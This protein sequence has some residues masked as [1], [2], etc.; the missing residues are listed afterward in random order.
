MGLRIGRVFSL[1]KNLSSSPQYRVR[2]RA[3]QELCQRDKICPTKQD[4]FS[5][6]VVAPPSA[7][8]ASDDNGA[9][10]TYLAWCVAA[11]A[12][13]ASM[14][15]SDHHS[16]TTGCFDNCSPRGNRALGARGYHSTVAVCESGSSS[17]PP[18]RND[19]DDCSKSDSVF[20]MA[21]QWASIYAARTKS[22]SV[23]D[24]DGKNEID[25]DTAVRTDESPNGMHTPEELLE[26]MGILGGISNRHDNKEHDKENRPKDA[27]KDETNSDDVESNNIS[28]MQRVLFKLD[29]FQSSLPKSSP[30]SPKEEADNPINNP[31]GHECEG[32]DNSLSNIL[33]DFLSN[34]SLFTRKT[35]SPPPDIEELIKQAQSIANH[36]SSPP[37]QSASSLPS[38]GFLSQ[39]LYFQQNAQS[40]QRAFEISFGS[41]LKD[42]LRTSLPSFTAM[43]YYLEHEDSIKT[44][45]WKRLV[46]RFHRDV[47]LTKVTELNEALLLSELG[48]ADE[49]TEIRRR[50]ENLYTGKDD[51]PQWELLFC[52][53]QSRPNKPSHFL[54][55]Q[56]NAP[57]YDDA[58]HVLMVVR[59]TKSMSDLITDAMMEA[60]EYVYDPP[61]REDKNRVIRGFAHGGMVRSGKYLV[62]RHQRLLSTLL[63]LSKK[64]RIE[65]T[66]VGHS[67]GAG[68]ATIAA[69]E[70]NSKPFEKNSDDDVKVGESKDDI[71]VTARVI[72]FGCPA[73]LSRPLS[74][75]TKDYVTTVIADADLIPRMSGATLVNLLLDVRGFDYRTHAERDVEQALRELQSRLLG[76]SDVVLPSEKSKSKLAFNIDEEDIQTVLGYVH[77]GLEKVATTISSSSV[78]KVTKVEMKE[79]GAKNEIDEEKEEKVKKMQPILF[80]PGECIHFY[81]DGSGISGSYVPCNFFNEID[82]ARTMIDDH[83]IS[84]GYRRIFLNLMRDFHKDDHFSFDKKP[85]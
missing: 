62:E 27:A 68:A 85:P 32:K 39:V 3:Q 15:G 41:H 24:P 30:S 17:N 63:R 6:S 84:S 54:A 81:R 36:V 9:S 40:I 2:W 46:H 72:G 29:E 1:G 51:K 19:G 44:P 20:D 70:W 56:K 49:V 31:S 53:T 65:I 26:A 33:S 45:S 48:Y 60:S 52:D 69:M 58:L 43:H 71:R 16:T 67:L 55:I 76:D 74:L 13:A 64:R 7:L 18:S 10:P 66:L 61:G 37:S 75:A 83:L 35:P 73:L 11:S 25:D 78:E 38:S 22:T 4:G 14:L 82:V 42:L 57:S 28:M 47:E 8:V 79:E 34:A 80:P 23:Q 50:L 59:G 5:S 21:Q 12:V 77:R